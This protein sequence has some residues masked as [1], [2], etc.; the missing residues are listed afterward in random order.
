MQSHINESPLEDS[1]HWKTA[2]NAPLKK[3]ELDLLR[4]LRVA[5]ISKQKELQAIARRE[6]AAEKQYHSLTRTLLSSHCAEN[7]SEQKERLVAE[8]GVLQQEYLEMQAKLERKIAA[9]PDGYLRLV[10][11]LYYVDLLTGKSIAALLGGI[12]DRAIQRLLARYFQGGTWEE[13]P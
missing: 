13:R 8:L 9:V 12:S 11:S 5:I 4:P 2:Y 7:R 1:K 6:A 10:L 3:Q